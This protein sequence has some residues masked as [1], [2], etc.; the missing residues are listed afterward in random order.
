MNEF[1][2]DVL[3]VMEAMIN[4]KCFLHR[5]MSLRHAHWHYVPPIG[6]VGGFGVVWKEDVNL[7]IISLD[8]NLIQCFVWEGPQNFIWLF[9]AIY[10]PTI[11]LKELCFGKGLPIIL[12]LP[13]SI[14]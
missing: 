10:G 6:I 12:W 11:M 4:N 14:T 3:V 1:F 13:N 9:L 2:L 8:K 5:M 7:E